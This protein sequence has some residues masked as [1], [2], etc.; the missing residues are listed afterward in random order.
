M[1]ID[2]IVEGI[3]TVLEQ[4]IMTANAEVRAKLAMEGID[5]DTVT[6]LDEVF[7]DITPFWRLRN[8]FQ[9]RKILQR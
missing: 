6:G 7:L 1:A 5:P 3:E 4:S 8:W 9:A 2:D